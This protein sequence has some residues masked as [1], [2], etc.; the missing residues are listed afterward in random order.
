MVRT[1]RKK[2]TKNG[3]RTA[4]KATGKKTAQVSE[5]AEAG[6]FNESPKV[7]T[8]L[9]ER[10]LCGAEGSFGYLESLSRTSREA[11][12]TTNRDGF[13]QALAWMSE[14]EWNSESSEEMSETGAGS[15][16]CECV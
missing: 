5:I 16:E 6:I 11:E 2:A 14:P 3:R 1:T 9:A 10:A 12:A 7:V 4:R 15:R 8:H 13:S